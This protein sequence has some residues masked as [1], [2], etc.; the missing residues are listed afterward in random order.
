MTSLKASPMCFS[1]SFRHTLSQRTQVCLQ[2]VNRWQMI[3][4][5]K[6]ESPFCTAWPRTEERSQ[7]ACVSLISLFL[8]WLD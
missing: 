2:P 4:G 6:L 5:K 1:A 8:L 3:L 7:D